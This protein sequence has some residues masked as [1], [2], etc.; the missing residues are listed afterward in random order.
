MTEKVDKFIESQRDNIKYGEKLDEAIT[1]FESLSIDEQYEILKIYLDRRKMDVNLHWLFN[2]SGGANKNHGIGIINILNSKFPNGTNL[3]ELQ[4][5]NP[6]LYKEM[7]GLQPRD[8]GGIS[9]V[10][11]ELDIFKDNDGNLNKKSIIKYLAD[12]TVKMGKEDL[13][14][15]FKYIDPNED[16][17]RNN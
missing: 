8:K 5:N 12:P 14:D 6:K 11:G 15:I 10:I 4:I 17:K 3:E 1:A 9:S 7:I 13:K 2:N 16:R